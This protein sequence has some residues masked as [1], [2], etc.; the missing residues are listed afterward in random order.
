[1]EQEREPRGKR[2]RQI[3]CKLIPALGDGSLFSW[4]NE[5][6]RRIAEQMNGVMA[7]VYIFHNN[8]IFNLL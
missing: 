8:F 2:S 3:A 5:N 6:C 4:K 7:V 1:M